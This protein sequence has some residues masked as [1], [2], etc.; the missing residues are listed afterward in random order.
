MVSQSS[1]FFPYKTIK[2]TPL[3]GE[4]V[5][6]RADYNVPLKSDGKISDDYRI[7]QSIPTLKY[8]LDRRC[9]IVICSHLG[10]PDGKPNK[11]YSLQPVADR[12]SELL[13]VDVQF[14]DESVSEKAYQVVKKSQASVI[15]LENLRFHAE[16]ETNDTEFAKKLKRA[17][18]AKYF[19]QDGFGV[20]H[21]AHASTSA[22]TQLLPSVAGLLLEK[23]VSTINRAMMNPLRPLVAVLGG[24]KIS[25]KLPIISKFV[26]I[27]DKV[28][29]GGAMANTFLQ[30]YGYPIGKSLWEDDEQAAIGQIAEAV[31][32]K[33]G[34]DDQNCSHPG[35]KPCLMCSDSF[36]LPSDVVVATEISG[37]A[38]T[39][40]KSLGEVSGED[41]IL[42]IG[43]ASAS[44][45]VNILEHAH[46]TIWNGTMGYAE[47][48][49]FAKG[50]EALAQALHDNRTTNESII[51]GGDTADFVIK[52][53]GG[54]TDGFGHISTGGG[55]SL[56]LM[57]GVKLP[58]VEALL[59]K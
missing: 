38:A 57:A 14:V 28:L 13:G 17:S 26:E 56:D 43:T 4:P 48:S 37:Q 16:E 31:A 59:K 27:A 32:K 41:I 42:D 3:R 11:K 34:I 47:I 9:K 5:L 50:S 36:I 45:Y 7:T 52:W 10:R 20:V 33:F 53:S 51:G 2:N 21:R 35:T 12:L 55:A 6:V 29:I 19:V 8:L 24:A 25:D 44:R 30:Y 1:K 49:L 15:L 18:G 58:G 23:E 22:I 54:K 46:T 40:N 39:S